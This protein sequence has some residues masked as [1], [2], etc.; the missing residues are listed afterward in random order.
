MVWIEHD[1]AIGRHTKHS[2]TGWRLPVPTWIKKSNDN[3]RRL[4]ALQHASIGVGA[5]PHKIR[6]QI[7]RRRERLRKRLTSDQ[8]VHRDSDHRR[9]NGRIGQRNLNGVVLQV[10]WRTVTR[11]VERV[12]CTR[13]RNDLAERLAT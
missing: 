11:V 1:T 5:V 13:Q 9:I 6:G 3:C 2:C 10:A 4:Y 7:C 8:D 12:W